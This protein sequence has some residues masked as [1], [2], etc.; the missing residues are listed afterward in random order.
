MRR[1]AI[2]GHSFGGITAMAYAGAEPATPVD[3]TV[4]ACIAYVPSCTL[5][6]PRARRP[7]GGTV[8]TL[9]LYHTRAMRCVGSVAVAPHQAGPLDV[10]A[11][12]CPASPRRTTRAYPRTVRRTVHEVGPERG[13]CQGYVG[14]ASLAAG[15]TLVLG[16]TADEFAWLLCVCP[17]QPCCFPATA[18]VPRSRRGWSC[19]VTA[20]SPATRKPRSLEVCWTRRTA[21]HRGPWCAQST[22]PST[23]TSVTC[24][25]GRRCVCNYRRRVCCHSTG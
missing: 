25:S 23:R 20:C 15:E 2:A 9:T 13:A 19:T 3:G 1:V 10:P 6:L 24:H 22:A 21:Q 17:P 18:R 7:R 4:R 16:S 5:A 14:C 11:V 8:W 12:T